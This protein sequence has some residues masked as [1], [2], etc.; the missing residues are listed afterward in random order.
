MKKLTPIKSA[1]QSNDF[2]KMARNNM[3]K[4]PIIHPNEVLTLS[5]FFL[6]DEII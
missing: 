6:I 4:A 3:P 5:L 2:G 1:S